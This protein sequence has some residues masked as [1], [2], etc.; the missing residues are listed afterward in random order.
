MRMIFGDEG[1]ALA[2]I[3]DKVTKERYDAYTTTDGKLLILQ[4][5]STQPIVNAYY[6]DKT[7]K[8]HETLANM[9]VAIYIVDRFEFWD[10]RPIGVTV[11]EE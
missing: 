10:D 11:R 6:E 1:S 8:V 9:G 2:W 7:G 5:R 4:K 3:N